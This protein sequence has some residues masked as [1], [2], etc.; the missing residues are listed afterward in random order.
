MIIVTDSQKQNLGVLVVVFFSKTKNIALDIYNNTSYMIHLP[1][2][3]ESLVE[4]NMIDER[5]VGDDFVMFLVV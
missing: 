1:V 5:R 4:V 2:Y 3:L